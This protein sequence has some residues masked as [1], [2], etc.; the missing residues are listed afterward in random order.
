MGVTVALGSCL[1]CVLFLQAY[2]HDLLYLSTGT[3]YSAFPITPAHY[4]VGGFHFVVIP[5]VEETITFLYDFS[6]DV[7]KV[8]AKVEEVNTV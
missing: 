7:L 2:D 1:Y 8:S 4:R 3:R 6:T 5:A